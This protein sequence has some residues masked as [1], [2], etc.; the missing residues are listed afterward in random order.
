M[1]ITI[2]TPVL[3]GGP[4]LR[5]CI[6]SV[7]AETR[8]GVLVE[9]LIVDG[10]STDGSAELAV[11]HGVQVLREPKV[12]LTGRMNI[13]YRAAQGELIGFLGADDVL[14]P[15]T[16]EAVVEAYRYRWRR[17][18]VGGIRWIAA[19]GHSLGELR[20]PPRW[21]TAAAYVALDWNVISP[22]ATYIHRD[23]FSQLGGYDERYDVAADFQLFARALQ[24]EP[25]ERVARPLA[26]WRRH[27]GNYSFVHN[28]LATLEAQAIR[29]SLG[30]RHDPGQPLRRCAMKAWF[31]LRNPGWCGSKLIERARLRLAMASRTPA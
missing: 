2:V 23:F 18:V 26:C 12:G 28:D 5:A 27:Q 15:G 8:R 13:G 20:A 3:N 9:H 4:D 22:M 1:I 21:M 6:E 10:G 31:N 30:L 17:W 19:D 7:K 24:Q 16:V 25:F 11:A 29:Q 14:L